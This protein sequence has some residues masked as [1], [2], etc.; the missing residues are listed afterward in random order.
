MARASS[1]L[2]ASVSWLWDVALDRQMLAL[3][4]PAALAEPEIES[5]NRKHTKE[6]YKLI[7]ASVLLSAKQNNLKYKEH[8][9]KITNRNQN[10]MKIKT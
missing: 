2:V 1:V 7:A 4:R 5:K 8:K 9:N 10:K 6:K 3:K